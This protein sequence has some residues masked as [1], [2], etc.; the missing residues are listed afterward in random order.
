MDVATQTTNGFQAKAAGYSLPSATAIFVA[1]NTSKG[2]EALTS[3]LHCEGYDRQPVYP[4][5]PWPMLT[6]TAILLARPAHTLVLLYERGG[7][8]LF[9]KEAPK[10]LIAALQPDSLQPSGHR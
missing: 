8:K 5:A 3:A 7:R 2:K 6:G 4:F 1:R 9:E 10:Y